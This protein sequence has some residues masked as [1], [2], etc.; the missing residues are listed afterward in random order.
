[1]RGMFRNTQAKN[2]VKH[3]FQSATIRESLYKL[4]LHCSGVYNTS[5]LD[6]VVGSIVL[7]CVKAVVLWGD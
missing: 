1:M 3:F 2:K 5:M 4:S 6:F 7:Y